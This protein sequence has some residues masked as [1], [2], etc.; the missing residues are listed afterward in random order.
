MTGWNEMSRLLAAE[1]VATPA[2]GTAEA[3]LGRL[4]ASLAAHTTPL[5]VSAGSLKLGGSLLGK[6]VG[7]GFVVGVAGAGAVAHVA[8]PTVSATVAERAPAAQLSVT[9]LSRAPRPPHDAASALAQVSALPSQPSQIAQAP[10]SAPQQMPSSL[11]TLDEELRLIA[12]AKREL[13]AGRAHLARPWLDEHRQRFRAGSLAVE[14]EGLDALARCSVAPQ[15]QLS[16]AFASRYPGSPLLP[17]VQRRCGAPSQLGS[18][19]DFS[20]TANANRAAGEPTP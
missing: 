17:Q 12:A 18:A 16:R 7:I 5:A 2:P 19:G 13:D 3:G 9:A 8:A 1:R 20:E 10:R 14:R 6:W 15:P 11:P 4:L